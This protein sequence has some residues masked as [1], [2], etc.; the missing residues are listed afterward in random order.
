M[1]AM[2]MTFVLVPG[3]GGAA[4][5]WHLLL[6]ELRRLGH[7]AVAVD[8]PAADEEAGLAAYADAIVTAAAGL[9][10]LV[11][12][13]HSMGAFSAPLACDRLP[14]RGLVLV[15]AMIP[16]PGES[17][18]DWWAATGQQEARRAFDVREGR[19][20]DAEYDE[21]VSFFHDV[22][23]SVIDEYAALGEPAQAEK[24]CVEPWP[25]DAWPTVPTRVLAARD[26]RVFPHDFQVRVARERLGVTPETVPGG[27]MCALSRPAELARALSE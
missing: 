5:D 25:L 22:P 11:L 12:V 16:A 20:P 10:E 26:D 17:F 4:W 27:H 19:D 14:V 9:P 8:L 15:N 7:R 6:P 3:A 1:R 18:G 23:Q 13:A 2:E 21:V 24:P